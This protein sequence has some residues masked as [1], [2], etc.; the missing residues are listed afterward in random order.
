MY[1]FRSV[2]TE[3]S[4]TLSTEKWR[5]MLPCGLMI[6]LLAHPFP[7]SLVSKASLFLISMYFS[8]LQNYAF[9]KLCQE[10]YLKYIKC[11]RH[12]KK[13]EGPQFYYEPG[14]LGKRRPCKHIPYNRPSKNLSELN[15]SK[16]AILGLNLG[17]SSY[18]SPKTFEIGNL[19]LALRK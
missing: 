4:T 1:Y 9:I 14:S 12:L 10:N 6:W 7:P 18:F 2:K 5:T 15:D 13:P 19:E 16:W 3:C 11:I 17:F 8:V